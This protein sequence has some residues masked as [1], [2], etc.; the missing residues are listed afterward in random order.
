[1]TYWGFFPK[2]NVHT[3]RKRSIKVV[4][5]LSEVYLDAMCEKNYTAEGN[6]IDECCWLSYLIKRSLEKNE[7]WKELWK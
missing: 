3:S 5:I 1:M 2:G 6:H 4:K 7:L